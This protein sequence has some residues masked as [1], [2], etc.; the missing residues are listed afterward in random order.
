M[1]TVRALPVI[2]HARMMSIRFDKL[3][4]SH[5]VMTANR[6]VLDNKQIVLSAHTPHHPQSL[7]KHEPDA[8]DITSQGLRSKSNYIVP[9]THTKHLTPIGKMAKDRHDFTNCDNCVG[10]KPKCSRTLTQSRNCSTWLMS[11]RVEKSKFLR[12]VF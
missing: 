9:Q 11:P 4:A 6:S 3:L 2:T 10:M 7:T 12:L 1:R 5:F 8:I